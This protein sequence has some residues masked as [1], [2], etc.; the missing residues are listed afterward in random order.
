M[1]TTLLLLLM[2]ICIESS[3]AIILIQG[4]TVPL[5]YQNDIYYLPTN[6]VIPPGTTNLYITMDGINKICFL[7]RAP[8][9]LF[10][11]ISEISI[12]INGVK[13]EWNCFPYRT[14]VFEVRP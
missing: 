10:E 7:N 2:L 6:L 11:Q 4:E 9:G 5:E 3:G 1:K 13:T 12:I 14:T 8:S